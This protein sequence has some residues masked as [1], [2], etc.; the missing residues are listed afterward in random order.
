MIKKPIRDFV[1]NEL[2]GYAYYNYHGTIVKYE[3]VKP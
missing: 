3:E 2:R 1:T